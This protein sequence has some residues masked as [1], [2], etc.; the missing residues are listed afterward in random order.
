[1][2]VANFTFQGGQT[3]RLALKAFL[4]TPNPHAAF[5]DLVGRRVLVVNRQTRA[6]LVS[7]MPGQRCKSEQKT[8]VCGLHRTV[9]QAAH[10]QLRAIRTA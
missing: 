2:H 4:T 5:V 3:S 10:T 8:P 1:M 9:S 7:A 6:T